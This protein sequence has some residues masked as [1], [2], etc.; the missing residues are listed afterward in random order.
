MYLAGDDDDDDDNWLISRVVLYMYIYSFHFFG[1]LSCFI[2]SN[3][4][5][6]ILGEIKKKLMGN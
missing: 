4:G 5:V 2:V 6:K 3:L 1:Q